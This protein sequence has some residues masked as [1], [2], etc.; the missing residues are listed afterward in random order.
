MLSHVRLFVIPWAPSGSFVHAILQAR[1]LQ[2]VAIPVSRASSWPRHQTLLSC[3][4]CTGGQILSHCAIQHW[5]ACYYHGCWHYSD[6]CI[7]TT[8][9]VCWSLSRVWFFVTPW[10]VALQASPS[11]GFSRQVYWSGLPLPSPGTLPYPGSNPVSCLG[12]WILY[13]LS[14][15]RSNCTMMFFLSFHI[16]SHSPV[17][18][19][20]EMPMHLLICLFCFF[21]LCISRL[22]HIEIWSL[23]YR[24]HWKIVVEWRDG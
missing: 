22:E 6:F 2:W 14:Y 24:N 9:C 4:S 16:L 18:C 5:W 3:I 23:A 12:R 20:V 8:V 17:S 11:L 1:M 19:S 21:N 13:H 7:I 10:T 15:Q